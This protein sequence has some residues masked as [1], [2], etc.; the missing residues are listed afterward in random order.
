MNEQFQELRYLVGEA[1]KGVYNA[2]TVYGNAN[3]VQDAT[4]LSVYRSLKPG[5]V[6][7]P[8]TDSAWWFCIIDLSSIKAEADHLVEIDQQMTSN[9]TGR[10]EAEAGRVAAETARVNAENV[11]IAAEQTRESQE[12]ARIQAEQTRVNQEAAR[13]SA[14]TTRVNAESARAAAEQTRASQEQARVA[15]ETIR[16]TNE[17]N[18]IGAEQSRVE[19]EQQRVVDFQAQLAQQEATFEANEVERD[20]TVNAK[21]GDITNLQTDVAG[22]K[23]GSIPAGLALLAQLADNLASWAGRTGLSIDDT[24]TDTVRTAAGD[25]SIDSAQQ[26]RIVSI[27]AKTDF[28]ASELR[29]TGFNLLHGATAVGNGYYFL[30]PALSFGTYATAEKPNG[31]LFTDQNGANLQPTVYFKPIANGVPTSVTDGTACAYTDSNNHRFY[32]TPGVGYMIV[33]GI[34]LA[35]TCA[36]V[37]WSRRYDEFISPT[38]P[39]DAG[40]SIALT[41]II[42][43]VHN[44]GLLL[45]IFGG[46]SDGIR[47]G[48]TAA[49]WYRYCDRVKPEWTTV[50]QDT[51]SYLHTATISGM[52]ANGAVE[53]G[54]LALTVSD[55]TISYTDQSEDATT[56]WVKYELATPV[57]GNVTISPMLSIE[58][59]GLEELIGAVGSAYVTMQYAQNYP[60]A[61]AALASTLHSWNIRVLVEAVAWLD[62]RIKT[63]D[64]LTDNQGDLKADSID[65]ADLPK[66]C[67]QSLVIEGSG[68]PAIVPFFAGQRYHDTVGKKVYEAFAVTNSTNDW[69]LLN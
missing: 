67:G 9:E 48:D 17:E 53:C 29:A 69:V 11:R 35:N 4:G 15:A 38:N 14:E 42:N 62:A 54:N 59:W 27:F 13:V 63:L 22:L 19:A 68:A 51:G 66:V 57:T 52:K 64:A 60:D 33:S 31:I 30:V 18:R 46:P 5:N 43:A 34:T 24:F 10:V 23:S 41:S 3:V 47:F 12:S 37:G 26:A 1:W 45:S 7:H 50:E 44:Y 56:D 28:S 8:L 40:S 6:G 61:L 65:T 55:T 32:T 49:T 58:D 25:Q 21:V 39:A 2:A 16:Q 20:A 36:H